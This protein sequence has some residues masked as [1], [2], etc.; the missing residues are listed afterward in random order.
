MPAVELGLADYLGIWGRR[1][2][3]LRGGN[4]GVVAVALGNRRMSYGDLKSICLI[5]AGRGDG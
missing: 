5:A 4:R 1:Q 3:I 2:I